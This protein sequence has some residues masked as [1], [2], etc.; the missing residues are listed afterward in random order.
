[1]SNP[2]D[3]TTTP[4]ADAE[5]VTQPE[6]AVAETAPQAASDVATSEEA[7]EPVATPSE[8]SDAESEG[9]EAD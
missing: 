6:Q 9:G 8:E 4:A 7:S 1:M 3:Q 2:T 5:T